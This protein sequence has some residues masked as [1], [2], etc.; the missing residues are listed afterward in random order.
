MIEDLMNQADGIGQ[1]YIAQLEAI[2][3]QRDDIRRRMRERGLLAN[4]S[5]LPI[6]E[7]PTT[8]GIDGARVTERLLAT[9]VVAIAAI[10]VEGMT[11][12]SERHHW[13]QP[14]YE[15][16]LTMEPHYAYTNRI[17]S[18][19]M[20]AMELQLATK[21]PHQV[22]FID[23]S[24]ATPTIQ[25][26]QAM[27]SAGEA[28]YLDLTKKLKERIY[29][30]LRDYRS[31]LSNSRS[32]LTFVG[33]PKYT[34]NDEISKAIG[35]PES[36]DDRNLMTLVLESGE[37]TKPRRL[38]EPVAPWHINV[39]SALESDSS[40]LQS[41]ADETCSQLN[42][43]QVLYYRPNPQIPA[44]RL[45]TDP[46]TA[47]NQHR[48]AT[49]LT[50]VRGQCQSPRTMEPFPLFIADRMIKSLSPAMSAVIGLTTTQSGQQYSGP[51]SDIYHGLHS[52]RT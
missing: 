47:T 24:L 26:N 9:D 23:N 49:L 34:S 20:M 1:Q 12:P 31:I 22:I 25:L 15:T 39:S 16:L 11:P 8:C 4:Y 33:V 29:N 52:Y 14:H 51:T 3:A 21:A 28:P 46:G 30:A 17:A 19:L 27:A 32:D 6:A 10:A 37:Y 40:N 50:A 7:E 43:I 36:G 35:I 2:R 18:G 41:L 5:D 13:E 44:L 42:N 48:L 45:E 38:K